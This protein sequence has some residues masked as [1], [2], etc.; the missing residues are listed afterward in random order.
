MPFPIL[1]ISN[2]LF[3]LSKLPAR[4]ASQ[5]Q[6]SS[7]RYARRHCKFPLLFRDAGSNRSPGSDP[8]HKASHGHFPITIDRKRPVMKRFDDHQRNQLFR[9]MIWSIVVGTTANCNRKS[10]RS[11]IGLYQ[12]ICRCLGCTVRTARMDRVSSVKNRSGRSSGRSP[13]TSSVET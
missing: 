9:Q 7:S 8:L 1:H 2:Q 12:K 10:I 4:S 13:Y 6:Y 3:R 5:Y 11:V